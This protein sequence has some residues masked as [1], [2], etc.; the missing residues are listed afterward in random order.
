MSDLDV[1]KNI[2][3]TEFLGRHYGIA[4]DARGGACCPFH[5]DKNPSLSVSQKNGVGLFN[6]HA[7]GA[8]GSILDFVMLRENLKLVDAVRRIQE[9]E[10]IPEETRPAAKP[11][12]EIVRTHSYT[13]EN[14][15]EVWQKVRLSNGKP[16]FLCRH[17]DNGKWI[18][19]LGGVKLRA[20]PYR[21]HA[22]KDEPAVVI[23]EGERDADT[24][25]GLGF[26]ATSGPAGK[27]SWKDE[28]T[29]FFIGKECRVLYDV[30]QDDAAQA[31][32]RK[33]SAV[34]KSVFVLKVPMP[35]LEDDVTDY[36]AQFETADEKHDAFLGILAKEEQFVPV[37]AFEVKEDLEESGKQPAAGIPEISNCFLNRYVSHLSTVTDASP[38]FLLFSGIALLSGV[39]NKFYFLYPRRTNLNLYILLLAPSTYYRKSTTTDIVSDYIRAVNSNLIFPDSF[40]PEALY[41]ILKKYPRGLLIWR[42][43]IQVKEFQLGAEYNKGLASFL[44]DLYDYKEQHKRWT[45]GDGEI[46]VDN[47]IV[48]ILSAGIASWFVE[49]LKKK[50]FEGGIW[51]RFIFVPAP[52]QEREFSLPKPFFPIPVIEDRLKELDAREEA[53]MDIHPILPAMIEWGREHMKQTLRMEGVLQA[54]FQRLE[55]MLLKLACLFQL[56]TDGSTVVTETA[57]ND[58]VAVIEYIKRKLPPFF[59]DEIHFNNFEKAVAATLKLFKKKK[60][61]L[62]RSDITRGARL[63]AKLADDVLD[64]LIAEDQVERKEGKSGPEGGAKGTIYHLKGKIT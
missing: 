24:L 63:N 64:Q 9:L 10:G 36:L 41:E 17:E 32:A 12:F 8:K 43:L 31:V 55:V 15:V 27:D 1:L 33:L 25:A 62:T 23:T 44:V 5:E 29:P 34:A 39:L 26:A 45:K 14:G 13:D 53:E 30:G 51:T 4:V 3:L 58:A 18:Y 2:D 56:A 11:K 57:F 61:D 50:D 20:I 48:S 35:N 59:R 52:E 7:C 46:V 37:A 38:L 54:V 22:I 16:K 19:N 40:T 42:E 21:L 60:K 49:N 6:C 47:P 28:T